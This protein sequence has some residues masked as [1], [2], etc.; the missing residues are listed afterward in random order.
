MMERSKS[1][2]GPWE[3]KQLQHVSASTDREPN[4]GGLVQT[5]GGAWYWVTHQG[6]GG[7]WE[8]RT[9]CLLPVTWVNG[10]PIIGA[11][12]S[13]GIGSM[14]WG[15]KVPAGGAA[16]AP[17]DALPGV[18]TSDDFSSS[19]L[20]MPW[21]WYYQPRADKW[22]LTERPG[23]LRLRAFAPLATNNLTKVG[24]TLTQRTLRTLRCTATVKLDLA[25][26]ADGQHAGLSHYAATYAGLGVARAGT[27]NT[28]TLNVNGTLTTGA[29][30]TQATVWIRST[31]DVNGVSQ[32]SYS[33]DGLTFTNVG[34]TYQMTWGGYRGDRIGIFTY[35]PK[36]TGYVDVDSFEYTVSPVRAYT[37]ANGKS[38]KLLDVTGKSVADGAAVIQYKATGGDNQR[39]TFQS[40]GDGYH[41]ITC[42]RSGKV[43]D[44][45]GG[46]ATEGA[47]IVQAMPS[48]SASQQWKLAPVGAGPAYTIVNRKSGKVLDIAAGSTADAAAAVQSVAGTGTDQQWTFTFVKP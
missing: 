9:L 43:L 18:V 34:S 20:K 41:T 23:F 35:N 44:V 19:S 38:G 39:W 14:V 22:S 10:W 7:H 47:A 2:A 48:G 29:Q 28:I 21:E 4:Q 1:L 26:L 36:G 46:S 40:T 42:M 17:L 6:S 45:A 31:W 24:N 27:T 16:G 11:V 33:L 8:G 15:G 32:F 13:D 37:V 25:G 30:I 12:G 5:P 3:I